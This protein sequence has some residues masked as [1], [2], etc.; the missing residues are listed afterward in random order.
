MPPALPEDDDRTVIRPLPTLSGGL[1]AAAMAPVAA[2]STVAG[3]GGSG[4]GTAAAARIAPAK[5]PNHA[6][7]PGTRLGEFEITRLVGEGGFGIVYAVFDH[8]LERTVALKE[9]MPSTLAERGDGYTVAVRSERHAETFAAGLKSFIN[10]ARLLAR[11]DHPALLKVHRFWEANGTAYMV[12]PF[13]EGPT[14]K[15]ALADMPAPPDEAWLRALL[16]PLLDALAVMHAAHCYHRDIAPDNI[17]LT[18]A[19]PLLLD[20]GAARRVITD[21]TQAL[22]VVLKPGYA[23]VEQ[24][25]DV[26]SMRQGPWTDLYALAGVVHCAITGRPPMPSIERLMADRLAP[27]TQRAAG[28]YSAGFLAAMDAALAVRPDDRPQ[29]I[30]AFRGL[31]DGAAGAM[32]ATAAGA[33]VQPSQIEARRDAAPGADA[34]ATV[35]AAD[36]PTI[37]RPQFAPQTAPQTA[38]PTVA[39]APTALRSAASPAATSANARADSA[40][41]AARIAPP[42]STSSAG[43]APA[44][45]RGS[46]LVIGGLA[47]LLVAGAAGWAL[48]HRAPDAVPAAATASPSTSAPAPVA[49]PAAGIPAPITPAP[50]SAVATPALAPAPTPA[51]IESP[52][53]APPAKPVT[54]TATV[55]A[56][57]LAQPAAAAQKRPSAANPDGKDSVVPA[58]RSGYAGADAAS[59]RRPARCGDLVLK[60]SLESLTADETAFLRNECK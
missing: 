7:P 1:G 56:P 27:L 53:T 30:A 18:A 54:A 44:A 12:M 41:P 46:T 47:A 36:L 5:A 14:L 50:A 23:P 45:R 11:F 15:R 32:S 39:A 17:L 21:M 60:A 51:P 16:A 24:Y 52:I 9:Y 38:L 58:T 35:A 22:T 6:L 19:G 42:P 49:A 2:V 37:V 43:S 33:T 8:S 31:M 13:Y 55:P 48:L 25:G 26:P 3:A 20:F 29:D 57:T 34:D 4:A 10:E 28:R 40:E 59:S